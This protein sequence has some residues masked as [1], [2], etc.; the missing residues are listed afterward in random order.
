MKVTL[1]SYIPTAARILILAKSTRLNLS[2]ELFDSLFN[3]EKEEIE[4]ELDYIANTVPSAWEF[5]HYTFLVEGVSRNCTHQMVRTRTG[6]YAEQSMRVTDQSDFD[7]VMPDIS[8]VKQDDI[9]AELSEI[10]YTYGNLIQGGVKPEDARSILPG[11]ISTNILCCYNLRT[12]ADLVQS[13]TGGRTQS[14]YRNVANAMV[15]AVLAVHPWAEKF[16]FKKQRDYFQEIEEFA[17]RKF[18]DL[19]ERGELLKIVDKMRKG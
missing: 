4:K 1:V 6:S 19:R 10:K 13:R 3:L 18:P 11:N 14:E 16:L 2:E 8:E 9:F 12:F 15:D 17:A 7:F 5:C